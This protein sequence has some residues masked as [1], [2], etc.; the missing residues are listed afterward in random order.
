MLNRCHGE[1]RMDNCPDN[2]KSMLEAS[3]RIDGPSMMGV[4]PELGRLCGRLGVPGTGTSVSSL[5]D[6][7]RS[8]LSG[9]KSATYS[10]KGCFIEHVNLDPCANEQCSKASRQVR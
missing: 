10:T 2:L 7:S 6:E 1:D 8:A 3:V 4:Q 5:G 9:V